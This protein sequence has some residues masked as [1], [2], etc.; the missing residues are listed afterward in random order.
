[1]HG[2]QIMSNEELLKLTI[3]YPPPQEWYDDEDNP[4]EADD[5]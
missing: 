5:E 1:M 3:L 4:F 2:V